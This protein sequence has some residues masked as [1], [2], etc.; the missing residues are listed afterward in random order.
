MARPHQHHDLRLCPRADMFGM[1][2]QHANETELQPKPKKLHE[3]PKQKIPLEHRLAGDGVSPERRI[4][5]Q[6]T[7][8][9]RTITSHRRVCLWTLDS[10]LCTHII[11]R[12]PH[13]FV[14]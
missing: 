8:K 7:G 9:P 4:D 1:Q 12:P 3:N 13:T 2:I 11:L 10:G 5:S 14:S 6:I